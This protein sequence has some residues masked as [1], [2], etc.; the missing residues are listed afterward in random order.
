MFGYETLVTDKQWLKHCILFGLQNQVDL[1]NVLKPIKCDTTSYK[2]EGKTLCSSSSDSSGSSIGSI[3]GL[4]G[5]ET[6]S[7][8]WHVERKGFAVLDALKTSSEF[9]EVEFCSL[10]GGDKALVAQKRLRKPPKRY[11]EESLEPKSRYF[12]GKSGPVRSRKHYCPKGSG[13]TQSVC[14]D[15]SFQRSC[16]QVPF[17]H[18]IEE[19]HLKTNASSWVRNIVVL[20]LELTFVLYIYPYSVLNSCAGCQRPN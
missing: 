6:M 1:D 16:I 15:K 10:D 4:F 12:K 20:W 14:L 18:P 7:V 3:N 11:I 5:D 8:D 19:E 9:S 2:I 13:A 17:G